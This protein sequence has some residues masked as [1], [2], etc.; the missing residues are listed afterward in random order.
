MRQKWD[1]LS[2]TSRRLIGTGVGLAF[3]MVMAMSWSVLDLR[4]ASLRDAHLVVRNLGVAISE[5]TSRSLQGADL[6]LQALRAD[7]EAS[8]VRTPQA[9]KSS[10]HTTSLQNRLKVR[11]D[12][13]PQ[14]KTFALVAAD[15][16]L[17]HTSNGFAFAP[18]DL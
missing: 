14:I 7:I 11:A 18:Q 9:F 4:R 12:D 6:V 5:Q 3:I 16:S 15:G 2:G 10:L 1:E 8:D 13:L 17:F